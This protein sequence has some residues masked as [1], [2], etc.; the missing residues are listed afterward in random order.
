M[1]TRHLRRLC[2]QRFLWRGSVVGVLLVMGL[3]VTV[4]W[5]CTAAPAPA[6]KLE[7]LRI[8]VAP[9]GFDTN[10]TWLAPRSSNLDKRPA[11]EFLVGIDRHTGAYIPELAEK[12]EMAP[13]GKT[14]TVW[15]RKGVKFHEHWGEFTARDVR[16]AVFLIT[17]PESV[18][19]S[20]SFWRNVVGVTKTDS[21]E[22]MARK[23]EQGVEIADDYRDVFTSSRW[24]RSLSR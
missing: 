3:V 8:A 15:L 5:V 24:C 22:E 11:L 20:A 19:T 13:D 17:Q 7:R 14:W 10:F 2:M 4:V 9:L 12:W 23:V 21:A 18:A 1:H 6:A 16:H